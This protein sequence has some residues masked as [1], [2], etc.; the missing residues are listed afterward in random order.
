MAAR[1]A[2]KRRSIRRTARRAVP[3]P[4]AL[5]GQ[6]KGQGFPVGQSLRGESGFLKQSVFAPAGRCY[7]PAA[8]WR[9]QGLVGMTTGPPDSAGEQRAPSREAGNRYSLSSG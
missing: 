3:Q 9:D 6:K 2:A 1:S 4:T 7:A 8:S 5:V